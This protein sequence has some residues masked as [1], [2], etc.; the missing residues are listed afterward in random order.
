LDPLEHQRFLWVS[1]EEVVNDLVKE[2]STSLE[3]ISQENKAVKL[4]AFRL[5]QERALG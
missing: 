4:E 5:Q 3:Y 1:E 2:G